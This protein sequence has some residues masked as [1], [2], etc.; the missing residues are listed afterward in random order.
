M[1]HRHGRVRSKE[2]SMDKSTRTVDFDFAQPT[3]GSRVER[4]RWRSLS[5][6]RQLVN[7]G[8]FFLGNHLRS[9]KYQN[10]IPIPYSLI[11]VPLPRAYKEGDV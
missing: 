11:S 10:L 5:A 9:K 4:S 2:I 1:A 8:T 6:R 3:D 7:G